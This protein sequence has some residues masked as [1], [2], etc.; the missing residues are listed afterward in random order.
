MLTSFYMRN[1]PGKLLIVLAV[2]VF[3]CSKDV[4]APAR[5][6]GSKG[7]NSTPVAT[8]FAVD[9]TAWVV[10]T[11]TLTW[12]AIVKEPQITPAVIGNGIVKV[13]IYRSTSWW[14]LPYTEDREALIQFGLEEGK[15]RFLCSETHGAAER[16]QNHLFKL[17]IA[18]TRPQ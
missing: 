1:S 12:E 18:E 9:S 2:F 14:E 7:K 5:Q 8:V 17:V 10:G 13:Y 4:E 6:P 3:A 15:I 16:P 11:N